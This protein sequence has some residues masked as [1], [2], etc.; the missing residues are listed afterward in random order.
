MKD[1]L[2]FSS[3]SQY[4]HCEFK[5]LALDKGDLTFESTEPML[6][7]SYVEQLLIGT[8]ETLQSFIDANPV[9]VNS[10][11]GEL[12]VAFKRIEESVVKLA[13]SDE[14]FMAF[15]QGDYQIPYE[16]TIAGVKVRGILDVLSED[17]IVDLKAVANFNRAWN[18]DTRT[19]QSFI[20][21]RNYSTQGAIYQ[22]LVYQAT[23]KR[24]PFILA[25][26]TK[27]EVPKRVLAT[28]RQET[29]DICL[30]RFID[31]IPRIMAIR[32]GEIEPERCGEC[33]HCR[34]HSEAYLMDYTMVGYTKSEL[35]FLE[36]EERRPYE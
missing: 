21:Q 3:W 34:L 18:P 33:E 6:E 26:T 28:F 7:S 20:E 31:D 14:T 30:Q 36:R 8:P 22:E 19:K 11:T 24:L 29:L 23:G 1:Y 25:A 10:R 2:S 13:R 32:N 17:R 9:I 5:A 27:E 15:L 16:G 12:K 35:E 4:K